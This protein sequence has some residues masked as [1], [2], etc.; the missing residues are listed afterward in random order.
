MT[1][2]S[3]LRAPTIG[4]ELPSYPRSSTLSSL[5]ARIEFTNDSHEHSMQHQTSQSPLVDT[6]TDVAHAAPENNGSERGR[7]NT[8]PNFTGP[9]HQTAPEVSRYSET[10]AMVPRN[11][12]SM[13]DVAALII[14]KMV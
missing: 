2:V 14:N 7:Q 4:H 6:E 11:N 9:D 10:D 8:G 12:L 13:Y 3:S 5:S 1:T